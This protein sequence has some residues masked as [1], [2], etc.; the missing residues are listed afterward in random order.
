MRQWKHLAHQR[1][2]GVG[3]GAHEHQFLAPPSS[4]LAARL[5]MFILVLLFSFLIVFF[6]TP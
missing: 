3:Q 5:F 2:Y 4:A 1:E 6:L